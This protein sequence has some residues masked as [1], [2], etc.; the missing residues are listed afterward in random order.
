MDNISLATN[1]FLIP[2][3]QTYNSRK[4]DD[5]FSGIL[6]STCLVPCLRTVATVEEGTITTDKHF[7]F[8]L[9]FS[10][11]VRTKKTSLV[12]FSFMESLNYLGSNLGLWPG[13]GLYQILQLIYSQVLIWCRMFNITF[14]K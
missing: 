5:L 8:S 14:L 7:K 2:E 13:L 3:G 11:E 6:P 12:R 1:T 10:N 4:Y 9:A